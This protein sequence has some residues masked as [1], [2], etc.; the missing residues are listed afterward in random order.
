[1]PRESVAVDV[2]VFKGIA[3]A[4]IFVV[5]LVGGLAP[6]LVKPSASTDRFFSLGNC[7]AAGVFLTTSIIHMLP[8]GLAALED[9][10]LERDTAHFNVG[11]LLVVGF[12]V[13]MFAERVAA[14]AGV[15]G[16]EGAGLTAQRTAV[17]YSLLLVLSLHSIIAGM[18]FGTEREIAQAAILLL[19]IVAHKGTEAFALGVS[20]LRGGISTGRT[21]LTILLYSCITP[22]GIVLGTLLQAALTGPGAGRVEGLFD[23]LAA[24]TFIYIAAGHSI[25]EEFEDAT[26]RWAKFGAFAV[27]VAIMT[28]VGLV[29]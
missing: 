19:A 27:G 6:L 18:T 14:A 15:H 16:A 23:G 2:A 24:G 28:M 26:D 5:A 12:A 1:M 11:L 10:G 20:L 4:A 21:R 7:L 8:D 17:A 22:L 29:A 13:A 9:A 25:P 3:I